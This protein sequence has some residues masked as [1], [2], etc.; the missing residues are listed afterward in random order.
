MKK[1]FMPLVCILISILCFTSCQ[2]PMSLYPDG[3]ENHDFDFDAI[4]ELVTSYIEDKYGVDCEMTT[5]SVKRVGGEK[6]VSAHFK[7]SE[8]DNEYDVTIY[9]EP[10]TDSDGDGFY[11][12]YCIKAENYYSY[13]VSPMSAEWFDEVVSEYTDYTNYKVFASLGYNDVNKDPEPPSDVDY[14]L[15]KKSDASGMLR[16]ILSE[17]YYSPDRNFEEETQRLLDY[18]NSL[19]LSYSFRI[20]VY[21]KEEF[22]TV[23]QIQTYYEFNTEIRHY[24]SMYYKVK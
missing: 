12:S 3:M 16:I 10:D 14:I 13:Y 6:Y 1:K 20:Y 11:D 23:E 8:N 7:T 17:E 22:E 5:G 4:E 2:P 15:N 9:P 21:D 19:E 18:L 24:L